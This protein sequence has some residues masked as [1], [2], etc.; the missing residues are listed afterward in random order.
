M[1]NDR[2]SDL[3]VCRRCGAAGVVALW[4]WGLMPAAAQDTP[5]GARTLPD[6]VDTRPLPLMD[7]SRSDEAAA[8][9]R[10]D[11]AKRAAA[12]TDARQARDRAKPASP[13]EPKPAPPERRRDTVAEER[14]PVP[15]PPAEK[16]V[17]EAAS[18]VEAMPAPAIAASPRAAEPV[19]T[20]SLVAPPAIVTPVAAPPATA[21]RPEVQRYL[22]RGRDLMRL[23]DVTSARTFFERAL[24][25]GAAD[26]AIELAST[27]DPNTLNERGVIGLQPDLQRAIALYRQAAD[28]GAPAAAVRLEQLGA[29]P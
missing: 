17:P 13:A 24:R 9:R 8:R 14:T 6:F 20:S 21:P 28:M 12:E 16:A 10:A 5:T 1:N 29:K 18:G 3:A 11:D 2:A 19:A 15:K 25:S 22:A 27:F 23:G 4:L 7:H 26:G